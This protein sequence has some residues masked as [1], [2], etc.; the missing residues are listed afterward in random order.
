MKMQEEFPHKAKNENYSKY[1]LKIPE[2]QV[3]I[4]GNRLAQPLVV[5]QGHAGQ[6][7]RVTVLG[8][9]GQ[10]WNATYVKKNT[11][12]TTALSWR[13]KNSSLV[14]KIRTNLQFLLLHKE[15][16]EKPSCMENAEKEKRKR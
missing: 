6:T 16:I 12:S 1:S 9:A 3:M 13:W 4:T 5:A 11:F 7:E 15:N 14:L 2:N 8:K 10:L